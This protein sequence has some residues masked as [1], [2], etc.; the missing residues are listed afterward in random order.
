MARPGRL[1]APDVGRMAEI[2]QQLAAMAP[3]LREFEARIEAAR[4]PRA[5]AMHRLYDL[6]HDEAVEAKLRVEFATA[7]RA[8][9]AAVEAWRAAEGPA[10]ALREEWLQLQ[11]VCNFL[12]ACAMCYE[13]V[14]PVH[15]EPGRDAGAAVLCLDCFDTGPATTTPGPEGG[16]RRTGWR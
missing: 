10:F 4:A 6:D 5:A 8:L 16:R 2:E 3:R 7:D 14:G 11:M 9:R 13:T 12:P 15:L 1:L